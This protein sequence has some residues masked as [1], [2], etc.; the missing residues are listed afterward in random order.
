[1]KGP[2]TY[3]CFAPTRFLRPYL[4]ARGVYR[5][6]DGVERD[7]ERRETENER[8]REPEP[9]RRLDD[10]GKGVDG[11]LILIKIHLVDQRRQ[12]PPCSRL[13]SKNLVIAS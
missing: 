3:Q 2:R 12:L 9:F 11:G 5:E 7:E 10:V 1:M 6:A 8:D 4:I 13:L